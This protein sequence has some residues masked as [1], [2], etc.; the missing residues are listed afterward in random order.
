MENS[1]RH[2]EGKVSIYKVLP[3]AIT[4]IGMCFGLTSIRMS[5]DG[6][7][8]LAVSLILLAAV[9]D[10]L[11]GL[12]A[13]Q[14]NAVSK[15]GAELDSL[16][17][18]LCF[19]VA[20]AIL[21]YCMFTNALGSFGWG[22]TLVYVAAS[23]LRLARF[24]AFQQ[25]S[26]NPEPDEINAAPEPHPNHEKSKTYFVG[27]PAPGAAL[28]VLLPVFITFASSLSIVISPY[29][30]TI[31]LC[32]IGTLMISR[33]KTF[34]PKTI[35]IPRRSVTLSLLFIV[36][37]AAILYSYTWQTFMIL[38]IIYTCMLIVDVIKAKGRII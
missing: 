6:Y 22:A 38:S 7:Y 12:V 15:F 25:S 2:S 3:S 34:S 20:P 4:I 29:F 24:N 28:L 14:L 30:V 23:C 5:L 16:T 13:R 19:G 36:A 1:T 17:D 11:D 27:V 8:E 32:I 21:L 18:F 35:R 31:W 26:V 33:L 37:L 10:G 9:A